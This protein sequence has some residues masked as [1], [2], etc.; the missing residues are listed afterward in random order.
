MS[1]CQLAEELLNTEKA[2]F[3][4]EDVAIKMTNGGN[5]KDFSRPCT[6]NDV[7]SPFGFKLQLYE[8]YISLGE[9]K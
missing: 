1:N 3:I 7:P 6:E 8:D 2:G 5:R 9:R 4:S